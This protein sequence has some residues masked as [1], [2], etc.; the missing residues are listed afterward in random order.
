MTDFPSDIELAQ[1]V[2]AAHRSVALEAMG[3]LLRLVRACLR[4][5]FQSVKLDHLMGHLPSPWSELDQAC[6]FLRDQGRLEQT[7][8]FKQVLRGYRESGNP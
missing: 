1:V 3:Y 7:E 6:R 8:V 5:G 4:D 2:A